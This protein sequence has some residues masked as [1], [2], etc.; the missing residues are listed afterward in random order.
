MAAPVRASEHAPISPRLHYIY[1]A[2]QREFNARLYIVSAP[3]LR[4]AYVEFVGVMAVYYLAKYRYFLVRPE[5]VAC[6]DRRV[7]AIRRWAL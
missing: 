2:A 5:R 6:A 3:S 1:H 7:P 4:S